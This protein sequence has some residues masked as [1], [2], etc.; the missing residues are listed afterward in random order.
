M[1]EIRYNDEGKLLKSGIGTL[2]TIY[3]HAGEAHTCKG[4]E[5][6]LLLRHCPVVA[7]VPDVGDSLVHT[8]T[9]TSDLDTLTLTLV[10]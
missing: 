4:G 1:K 5:N 10:R 3:H 2:I 7:D 6:T 8:V 9:Q